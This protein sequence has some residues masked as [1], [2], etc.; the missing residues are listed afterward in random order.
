MGLKNHYFCFA[1]VLCLILLQINCFQE[2]DVVITF[3]YAIFNETLQS[4]YGQV[5]EGVV[6]SVLSLVFCF[7]IS[8]MTNASLLAS[9]KTT[10]VYRYAFPQ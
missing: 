7:I 4:L 5:D 10:I 1:L 9:T 8:Y 3:I 2:T 6:D